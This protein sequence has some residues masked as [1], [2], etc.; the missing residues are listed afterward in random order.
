MPALEVESSSSAAE[1]SSVTPVREQVFRQPISLFLAM[2]A[3]AAAG[4]ATIVFLAVITRPG[5]IGLAVLCG[6]GA[7]FAC[8]AVRAVSRHMSVITISE[9]EIRISGPLRKQIAWR[10]TDGVSLR[11]FSTRRDRE[12]GWMSLVLRSGRKRITLDHE[13]PAFMPAVQ[14][15]LNA[16]LRNRVGLNA[17]TMTNARAL[18]ITLPGGTTA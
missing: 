6:I 15:A 2:I 17:A 13:H 14:H 5:V 7:V 9:E 12:N 11:Y 1:R 4:L 3:R 10:E 8:Y 16:A 18:G